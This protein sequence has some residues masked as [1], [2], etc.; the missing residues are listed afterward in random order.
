MADEAPVETTEP[1]DL[2]PVETEPVEPPA[3]PEAPAE[4]P[5][6]VKDL[7]EQRKAL[8][9]ER[10]NLKRELDEVRAQLANRDKPAEEIA[11]EQA[12]REA[13]EEA[14]NAYNQRIVTA[15]LKAALAGKV[16]NPALALKV[17]DIS[18]I[19]VSDG[20]EVD[21]QSVTDV[22]QALITEYPELSTG[23]PRPRIP[24]VPADP[25]TKPS[26]PPTLE[27]KIAA[28]QTAGNVAEV[29][30]LQN[31]RLQ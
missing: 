4:N 15:E 8:R 28:A 12:R 6:L 14:Q 25:A 30:A 19:E 1:T 24:D 23:V 21:M 31:Q 11:L 16:T 10:A 27:E 9:A 22:I 26:T 5:D 3:E 20:G 2:E 18:A 17:A 29:I 13:R 7:V